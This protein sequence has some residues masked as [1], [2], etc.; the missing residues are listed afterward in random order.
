MWTLHALLLSIPLFARLSLGLSTPEARAAPLKRDLGTSLFPGGHTFSSGFTTA[1][2]VSVAGVAEID[3][4]DSSLNVI[5]VQSGMT[6]N[7]VS[8]NG[9]TAWEAVY[10]EGSWN[11]S[12]T[13]LGGFGFYLG[14]SDAF[15][16]AI[17]GGAR[18][19]MFSYSVMFEDEFEFNKGGKLPGGCEYSICLCTHAS[20]V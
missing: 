16:S 4:S 8:Q 20:S 3:L 11:P 12:N 7:V 1:S 14:G 10:P 2:D 18:Q 6:H 19:V 15:K 5:K 17:D 9:K 13:P